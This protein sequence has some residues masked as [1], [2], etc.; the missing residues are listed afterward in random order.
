MIIGISGKAQSGKDTVC[1]MIQ[2]C[3]YFYDFCIGKDNKFGIQ[4]YEFCQKNEAV[5]TNFR[6][7]AFAAKLKAIASI[8]IN[9][10]VTAFEDIDFKNDYSY[11]RDISSNNEKAKLTTRQ[12]LQHIGDKMREIDPDIWVKGLLNSYYSFENWIIPDLRFKNEAKGIRETDTNSLLIRVENPRV[13]LMNHK[14][15]I[16][17]DDYTEWDYIINNDGT[18]EQ[19]LFKVRDI[20]LKE[21]IINE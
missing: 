15:E 16:D 11:V 7:H 21:K 5:V 1:K 14:S 6:K 18:L 8:L 3:A 2:Y 12:L 19:L 9:V 17:L 20:L 4:H 10:K 13:K